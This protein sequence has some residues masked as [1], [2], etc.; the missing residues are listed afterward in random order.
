MYR[1]VTGILKIPSCM[2]PVSNN[3]L[4]SGA[5]TVTSAFAT[6]IEAASH[7]ASFL[8]PAIVV[9]VRLSLGTAKN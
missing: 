2:T 8:A 6:F 1:R 3:F 5:V 4:P 7:V 9:G